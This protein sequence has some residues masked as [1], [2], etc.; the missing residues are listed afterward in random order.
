VSGFGADPGAQPDPQQQDA[1]GGLDPAL[2]AQM[3]QGAPEGGV[4]PTD[5]APGPEGGQDP[6]QPEGPQDQYSDQ[7]PLDLEGCIAHAI[8]TG[9]QQAAAATTVS[10]QDYAQL[11]AGILSLCQALEALQ[12]KT[13]PG[14][15]TLEAAAISALQRHQAAQLQ[16]AATVHATE[17]RGATAAQQ[18]AVQASRPTPS[19]T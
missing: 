1:G 11:S 8:E 9:A 13:D 18:A 2:L 10:A 6:N 7:H 17:S 19:G 15:A 5:G 4:V 16:H 3:Q 12:P 14:Q